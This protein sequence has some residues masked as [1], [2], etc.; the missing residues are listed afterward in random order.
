MCSVTG[1]DTQIAAMEQRSQPYLPTCGCHLPPGALS[2][3]L[4]SHF[5]I[6]ETGVVERKAVQFQAKGAD[7]ILGQCDPTVFLGCI[8]CDYHSCD[9]S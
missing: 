3:V 9:R 1:K 4:W 8:L 6:G 2:T 5:N 7:D